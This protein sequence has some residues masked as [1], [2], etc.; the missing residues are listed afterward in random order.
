MPSKVWDEF[1]YPFPNY[2]GAA[3]EVWEWISNFT[4]PIWWMELLFHAGIKVMEQWYKI[5]T[6]FLF[7]FPNNS[8]N[9]KT[10]VFFYFM[11]IPIEFLSNHGV[12]TLEAAVIYAF[13]IA[14][15]ATIYTNWTS[16]SIAPQS[17]ADRVLRRV[18]STIFNVQCDGMKTTRTSIK[19]WC[20]F[21]VDN[22]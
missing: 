6:H 12:C 20:R 4:P 22:S 19:P 3:V 11:L 9:I 17:V 8:E 14:F 21:R 15:R 13:K 18:L 10:I 5:H 7:F 16:L 1:T 2:D